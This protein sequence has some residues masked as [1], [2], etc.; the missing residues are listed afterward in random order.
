MAVTLTSPILGLEVGA[1]YTGPLEAW[2]LAEGYAKQTGY[3]TDT[4]AVLNGTTN[5]VNIVTGGAV[6]IQVD[7]EEYSATLANGDTPSAA[8]GKLDTALSGAADAAI[9]SSKLKITSVETGSNVDI[10]V[11]SGAGSTLANLGLTAGQ[12]A[13]GGDGG[14]GVSN[15]GPTDVL[16]AQD[17]TLAAN[18]EPAP[19]YAAAQLQGYDGDAPY[20]DG[21]LDPALDLADGHPAGYESASTKAPFDFDPAGVDDDPSVVDTVT[22]STGLAAGGTAVVIEG[23]GF[24]GATGVTFGGTPGTAFEVVDDTEV[25]VTTPAHAAGAVAV[26]VV[27]ANGNGTKANGFTYA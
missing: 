15:T 17:P 16:P 9:V 11:V 10:R 21:P 1:T 19:G 13:Q 26:V 22:P 14:P 23:S 12:A 2:A 7:N 20:D 5:A 25:H 3:D 27:D 6:V 8:A 18:R 4:A 24:E